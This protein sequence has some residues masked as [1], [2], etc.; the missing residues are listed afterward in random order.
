MFFRVSFSAFA[1]GGCSGWNAKGLCVLLEGV[2]VCLYIY[3]S[4]HETSAQLPTLYWFRSFLCQWRGSGMLRLLKYRTVKLSSLGANYDRVTSVSYASLYELPES[5]DHT[6]P[7][8]YSLYE[9]AKIWTPAKL[10]SHIRYV[11]RQLGTLS[12]CLWRALSFST[13]A[14]LLKCPSDSP[15]DRKTLLPGSVGRSTAMPLLRHVLR[16]CHT[17]DTWQMCSQWSSSKYCMCTF[18]IITLLC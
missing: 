17:R 15:S 1:P 11:C 4:L 8:T 16:A 6:Q 12:L 3:A 9:A 7:I 10:R 14:N 13:R 5:N 18:L 2:C